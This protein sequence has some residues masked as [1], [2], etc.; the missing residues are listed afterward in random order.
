[1]EREYLSLTE[2]ARYSGL[3]KRTLRKHIEADPA[4]ALPHYPIGGKIMVRRAEYDAWVR[5]FRSVGR[6]QLARN[7]KEL[8]MGDIATSLVGALP[9]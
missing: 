9:S 4:V 1:M 8:G 7:L 3:S 5:A 2:L 6:P